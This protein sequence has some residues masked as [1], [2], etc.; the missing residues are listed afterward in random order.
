MAEASKVDPTRVVPLMRYRDLPKAIAWLEKAFGFETHYTAADDDGSMIYAQMTY[1][2]GMVM[3][4][5]VRQSDF[6]D[7]LSQPDEIGGRETQSCYL[8][9]SDIEKHFE[10]SKA[11]GADIALDIQ[12]D[13]TGGRAYSC[14]DCE[15]HLW[16]FGTFNPWQS[17]AL[18]IS[19]LTINVRQ[20]HR[21]SSMGK[22]VAA[23]FAGLAIAGVAI[24]LYSR[25]STPDDT[26][27]NVKI[28]EGPEQAARPGDAT[29]EPNLVAPP[30]ASKNIAAAL[31]HELSRERQARLAAER[32]VEDVSRKLRQERQKLAKAQ[33]AE[34]AAIKDVE[35]VRKQQI[36]ESKEARASIDKL[37]QMI[38]SERQAK[39]EAERH[40]KR[41]ETE[42]ERER[43][44]RLEAEKAARI[45][46]A[47]PPSSVPQKADQKT[48]TK[49]APATNSKTAKA[50]PL[51][52]ES[53]DVM[54]DLD[55]DKAR[56]GN[57][58]ESNKPGEQKAKATPP[59]VETVK[60][61][62][63]KPRVRRAARKAPAKPKKPAPKNNSS[64][65]TF[66]G[67]GWPHNT[68]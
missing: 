54:K 30:V 44:L 43:R 63:A 12:S 24:G 3:L 56:L 61:P 33:G 1:G 26:L 22:S 23:V 53:I 11:A 18:P 25:H 15:G 9:V 57:D 46:R 5:P 62:P 21:R 31:R 20:E 2:H 51:D 41:I 42:L 10:R 58:G 55:A 65:P 50:A 4:G 29:D 45:T 38:V 48:S 7:L 6:D 16:N 28:I 64:V 34:A 19:K 59:K 49:P 14:R 39:I 68:W 66:G 37:R 35:R 36:D 13:E 60:K 40:A 8:V 47:A 17:A 27:A 52:P 32:R 67:S